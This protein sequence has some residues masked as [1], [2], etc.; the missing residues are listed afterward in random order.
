MNIFN[1]SD[2]VVMGRHIALPFD[3][4]ITTDTGI[5]QLRV[6]QIFRVVPGRRLVALVRWRGETMVAKLFFGSSHW[7]QT[8]LRDLQ[9]VTRLRQAGIATAKVVTQCPFADNCGIALLFE[10]LPEG[11]SLLE[12]YDAATDQEERNRIVEMGIDVIAQ[13]HEAGLCQRDLHLGNFLLSKGRVYT[14]DGGDIREIA[15]GL[16]ASSCLGNLGLFFAQ[17]PVAG[18]ACIPDWLAYYQAHSTCLPGITA[19]VMLEAAR[20]A[21]QQR[22]ANFERKLFRSTTAHR[23]LHTRRRFAVYDRSLHCPALEEVI[24]D[25]DRLMAGAIM[26]KEGNSSTVAVV[27]FEGRSFVLK[28]YNIK[29]LLH[30]L[31]RLFQP[32]RAHNS[33]LAASILGMLGIATP[34]PYMFVEERVV[35]VFRRRAWFLC[36]YLAED[37]LLQRVQT[38]SAERLPVAAI[39]AQFNQLFRVMKEYNISHGDM[40]ATNFLVH[41][42][43]LYVLDLDAMH[44][45]CSAARAAP[46]LLQDIERFQRNWVGTRFEQP[47]MELLAQLDR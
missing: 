10:Y 4:S 25:P 32:S 22:L 33:W 20:V 16:D 45:H 5:E 26:L 30:G 38:E 12:L 6:E 46:L 8:M 44:R 39:M 1:G 29:G 7:K 31:K 23:Q 37:N 40:K 47:V 18:D 21:R 15:D 35:W 19:N 9:G 28:R 27:Q 14:L 43:R 36:E 41:N 2:L 34:R 13:C 3:L 11:R 17:L 24:A 42:E